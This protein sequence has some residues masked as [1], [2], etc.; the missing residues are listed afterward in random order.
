MLILSRRPQEQISFPRLG[1]SVQLVSVQGRR[2]R[3]GI[4][5]PPDIE[6]VRGELLPDGVVPETAD[7]SLVNQHAYKNRLNVATLGLHLAQRQLAAGQTEAAEQSL[8]AALWQLA[9]LENEVTSRAP[10]PAAD[11]RA[12]STEPQGSAD[13]LLVEDDLNEQALL[14][15]LLELEGYKVHVANDGLEAL[16]CL[17]RVTPRFVLLDMQM[18]RCDGK[19]TLVRIRQLPRFRDLPVFAVSA[20]PPD[21]LGLSIGADGVDEWFSKPLD[22]PRLLRSLRQS[23]VAVSV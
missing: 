15:G 7:S 19:E 1:I 16:K 18:P 2:A 8:A 10:Q 6:V 21:T 4:T 12:G 17:S 13:V 5:A 14:R 3:L 22:T 11:R 20:S 23:E 9:D